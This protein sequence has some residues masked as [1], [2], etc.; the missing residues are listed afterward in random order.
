MNGTGTLVNQVCPF[1]F[2]LLQQKTPTE[3]W[4]VT[5]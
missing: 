3:R 4:G 2:L 1:P 5:F